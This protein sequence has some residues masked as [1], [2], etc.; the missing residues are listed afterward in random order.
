MIM[1]IILSC[2]VFIIFF[3]NVAYF[4]IMF[5]GSFKLSISIFLT[6]IAL[7]SFF[8]AIQSMLIALCARKD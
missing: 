4:V 8:A 7:T 3:S 5:A 6:N 1:Y 2:D